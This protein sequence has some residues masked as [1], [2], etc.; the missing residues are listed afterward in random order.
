MPLHLLLGPAGARKTGRLLD[1]HQAAARQGREAWLVVPGGADLVPIR[2]ELLGV[3]SPA[4]VPR[5]PTPYADLLGAP[6]LERRLLEAAGGPRLLTKDQRRVIA[7]AVVRTA[8]REGRLEAL[9]PAARRGW[10]ADEL[11]ALADELTITGDL[12]AGA[13]E[14]LTRWGGGTNG[15]RGREL[16]ELLRD[17]A[18]R[19]RALSEGPRGA[20]D[21]AT[22]A[23]AIGS[24]IARGAL[25]LDG[26]HITLAAFDDLDPVQ[27]SI[28]GFLARSAATVLL[29]LPYEQGRE[30]LAAAGPLVE[31]LR[32]AGAVVEEVP[33]DPGEARVAPALRALGAQLYEAAPLVEPG[34]PAERAQPHAVDAA[35][36]APLVELRGA[37]PDEELALIA[38]LVAE[39][40]EHGVAP[41][42]I[43]VLAANLDLHAPAIVAALGRRGISAHRSGPTPAAATPIVRGTM[44]LL[45]AAQALSADAQDGGEAADVVA[46]LTLV[47]RPLG[48]LVDAEVRRRGARTVR[49][50][51]RIARYRSGARI[52]EIDRLHSPGAGTESAGRPGSLERELAAI[53]DERAVAWLEPTGLRPDPGTERAIRAARE[54]SRMFERRARFIADAWQLR[55]SLAANLDDLHGALDELQLEAETEDL[56]SVAVV[57][58]LTL[59]T[60]SLDTLVI[61]RA[62]RG[63]FPEAESVRRILGPAD[64]GALSADH[65]WPVPI[66]PAHLAAQRYLAYEVAT[67]PVRRL[68]IGWHT[69]DGDG[70]AAEPSPLLA[71]IRRVAGDWL[72]TRTLHAGSAA[73]HG[74]AP[75]QRTA[76][77]HAIAGERHREVKHHQ[78]PL[79]AAAERDH[80]GVGA[81]QTA[82]RCTAQWFVDQHLRPRPLDPDAAPLTAGRLR[83]ELLAE[84]LRSALAD[85][86][87]LSPDALPALERG[88]AVAAARLAARAER[89]D[90]TLAERVLR[91]RVVAE[92]EATLPTLCGTADLRHQP[93]ELELAFGTAAPDDSGA[94][95]DA[96]VGRPPVVIRRGDHELRLSGRIDRLDVSRSGDEVVIVDYKGANV[97]PYRGAGWV[98]RRELQAGLYA[99]VAEALTGAEA[100]GS[101]YQPVPGPPEAPPRGAT[102]ERLGERGMRHGSNDVIGE[103]AWQELLD[104]LVALAAAAADAIDAGEVT[105]CPARCSDDGCRYPWLC[106]EQRG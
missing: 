17:D 81:L 11:I 38:D 15:R 89:G 54:A 55:V 75:E 65:G 21:R 47:D 23:L 104:E 62:Q 18:G 46:W 79:L 34:A 99:L 44:A 37:G 73:L 83:H 100:V 3:E 8:Q 59:R 30:A 7:Q 57:G 53:L 33:F 22:A 70:G 9:A 69:G 88:L 71:E 64:R 50:A 80:H 48:E 25:Q 27:R 20:I 77:A 96:P 31:E 32:R 51:L 87:E 76:L 90:E 103:D 2:R 95:D 102:V 97:E 58:P 42:R 35:E 39:E 5:T 91:E 26:V 49:D 24:A 13:E 82:S 1:A 41:H 28:V 85:G 106:R 61:A 63:S 98:E 12:G 68:A 43:A 10:L 19:R 36:D 16:A 60:R 105:P 6:A 74:L 45:R 93:S 86:V 67:T 56:G 4:G 14:A 29:S 92:V 84:L 78:S 101:L 66:A 72:H 40:L 94:A 52:E